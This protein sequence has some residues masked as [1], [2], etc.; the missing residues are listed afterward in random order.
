MK[1]KPIIILIASLVGLFFLWTCYFW[2]IFS[3]GIAGSYPC[4]ETWKL[5]ISEDE[6]IKVI[7]AVKT[8]HQ[9]LN[10]P[11]ESYSIPE[12]R[13]YWYDFTFYY[14]DTNEDVQT[15]IRGET[16][17][18]TTIG[19]VSLSP[20][21]DSLSSID[22][23]SKSISGQKDINRDYNFYANKREIS[24]FENK[25]LAIILKKIAEK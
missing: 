4:V 24:K 20:H 1:R 6:L 13:D 17:G 16:A 8:E 18:I 14:S 15:W 19:L 10:P 12:K 22:E 2:K 3:C 11:N 7:D 23:M 5:S 21:S 25:I 9:E